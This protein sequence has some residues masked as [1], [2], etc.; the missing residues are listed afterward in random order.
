MSTGFLI[1]RNTLSPALSYLRGR[2]APEQQ[3]GFLLA[4][5][6][7]VAVQAQRNALELATRQRRASVQLI[8][9]LG[10][11]WSASPEAQAQP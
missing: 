2:L 10:G 8:R 1:A 11:G 7:A 5:G 9:A 6:R 3:Q 4:W